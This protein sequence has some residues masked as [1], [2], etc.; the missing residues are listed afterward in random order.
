MKSF[1]VLFILVLAVACDAAPPAPGTPA[2]AVGAQ[3]KI[4]D[5]F[6][7]ENPKWKFAEGKWERRGGVLA[8]TAETQPWAVAILE[9]KM[10][11]DV[12]VS[13]RVKPLS[14]K[15][16][17]TGGIIFRVKDA[18]NYYLVRSNGL[19][20]NYRLYTMLDGK[21]SQIASTK[22]SPPKVGEWHTLRVVAQGKKIQAY[23]NDNLL[24]DHEDGTFADGY[25]G[26]WTKADSVTEFDDLEA[27]G[28][29]S[30]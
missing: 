27:T 3:E 12:D 13:I 5:D 25:V 6:E 26:V 17:Q 22:V 9:D 14:G 28:T 18:K 4:K 30:K 11:S 1:S 8:Q 2:L 16:D 24:I 23:I 21:R 7:K 15:E 20:D 19:E 10:F 29:A